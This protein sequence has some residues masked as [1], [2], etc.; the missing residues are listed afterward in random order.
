MIEVLS[1]LKVAVNTKQPENPYLDEVIRD[2]AVCFLSREA[3]LHI[4]RDVLNGRGKF[5][6]SGDGK[7]V[8]QVAMARAFKKG[9]FYS[10]YYRD[11]TLMFALD[12]ITVRDF[13]AQ[14][15]ADT[16]N[17]NHSGGRN[18]NNHF[19]SQLINADGS[20][21]NHT[22]QYNVVAGHASTAGQMPRALGLAYASNKYATNEAIGSSTMLSNKGKEVTFSTIGDAS[23]SEGVFWET[24]NAAGV[25]QT[26]LAVSVW[27]DGYGIS[28]PVELQTTKASIS[29]AL[30]GMQ[31]EEGVPGVK[32]YTA[33]GW[34][35]PSLCEMYERGIKECRENSEPVLFHVRELTQPQGHSTSGSHERYKSEKRLQW[36]KDHDCLAKM[37]SWIID[38]KLADET[39]LIELEEEI[40]TFVRKEKL[41]AWKAFTAQGERRRTELLAV[42][43]EIAEDK[44]YAE[45]IR[46]AEK[47]LNSIKEPEISEVI[48]LA[49]RTNLLCNH[50]KL[51]GWYLAEIASLEYAYEKDLYSSTVR[52][53][54]NIE[55][56]PPQYSENASTVN[57]FEILQ[58]NFDH[59][60]EKYPNTYLF[61]EDVGRIGDVNQ[62]AAGL[63]A[64]Y[65]EDR[66]F[67]T[68]IRE[69]TIMGQAQGMA[70]RGLRPIA[71][72]QYLD[73]LVYGLASLTDDISTLR[74]RSNN[75]QQCPAI[76]RTRGHRLEGIWH[77][78]SQ[79]GLLV[80][81]LRGMH[82]CVPRNMVQAAGFYNTLLKSDDPA[83][84]IE[85]L[86]GY[87]L[88][89][90]LPENIGEFT[91]PLGVPEILVEGDDLTVVTYGSCVRI[92]EEAARRLVDLD[93]HIEIIDI[94]TLL[95]FDLEHRIVASLKKTNKVIFFDEDVPGGASAYMMQEVLEKQNAYRYL[96]SAPSTL[97]AKACRPPYGSTGDYIVKP[98]VEDLVEKVVEVLEEVQPER[99][100]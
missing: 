84:V 73:Y 88:K 59:I 28:V 6:I 68:G 2:Y 64:K 66:V 74:F 30:A 86:N 20:W 36:E 63:Q 95:P 39:Q 80:N 37:R 87:R 69:W 99:F 42:Y 90:R 57:G 98:N 92:A 82:I 44:R 14:L 100:A 93:V 62:G 54:I 9:D 1:D 45:V 72:I 24:I 60:F 38:N 50:P 97:T 29:A 83:L 21:A 53:A 3:S 43:K 41:E 89:E 75:R 26:P 46:N 91:V 76:I 35:Y 55:V 25:L 67:D 15:Y 48:A 47:E 79:M 5:G 31:S 77:S 10:G 40:K 13:F 17:D 7:E 78:G 23:T 34:D 71:E 70:I 56:T 81:S 32:I 65:G 12:I 19:A 8:P 4:R 61:G 16:E 51:K 94:Q 58:R 85:S 33:K 11:Q 49:R 52:S 18:M 96:D 22:D 27:D